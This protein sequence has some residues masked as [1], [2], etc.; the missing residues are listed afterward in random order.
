MCDYR[1]RITRKKCKAIGARPVGCAEYSLKQSASVFTSTKV[2]PIGEVVADTCVNGCTH[3][4]GQVVLRD[5]RVTMVHTV[6]LAA[7]VS[8]LARHPS[9]MSCE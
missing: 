8:Q 3:D 9:C 5:G 2:E 6:V 4:R 7:K 1:E